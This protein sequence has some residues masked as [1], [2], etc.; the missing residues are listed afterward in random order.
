MRMCKMYRDGKEA[1]A[2]E[3]QVDV[4]VGAGWSREK[5]VVEVEDDSDFEKTES[6]K[7]KSSD[8]V[9]KKKGTKKNKAEE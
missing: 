6:E 4:M 7:E 3:S 5:P 1:T 2:C 8:P 9:K